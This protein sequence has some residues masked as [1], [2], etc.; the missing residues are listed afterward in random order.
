MCVC[1]G[2]H[3][4]NRE[5]TPF[6][7][8]ATALCFVPHVMG[9][10]VVHSVYWEHRLRVHISS[11]LLIYGV[12]CVYVDVCVCVDVTATWCARVC[13]LLYCDLLHT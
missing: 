7:V 11:R 13:P 3:T 4:T 12:K 1:D 8:W 10:C 2:A 9:V 6:G 5:V